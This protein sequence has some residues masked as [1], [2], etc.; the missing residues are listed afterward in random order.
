MM[1]QGMVAVYNRE[2]LVGQHKRGG[3]GRKSSECLALLV[4]KIEE[5][6]VFRQR[7]AHPEQ[8]GVRKKR[9]QYLRTQLRRKHRFDVCLRA[10]GGRNIGADAVLLQPR[11]RP[12]F[13][14][15]DVRPLY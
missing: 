12:A 10:F 2:R 15:V 13:K 1:L 6:I 7:K 5:V 9:Q 4:G 11:N 14:G 3:W 8:H